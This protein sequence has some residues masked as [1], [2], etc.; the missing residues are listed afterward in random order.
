MIHARAAI[1]LRHGNTCKSQLSGFL[2]IVTRETAG[3]VNF[4]GVWLYFGLREF[5]YAFLQKLL[6][7]R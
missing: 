2:E 3:L 7:F 6:F 4:L 1:I 5:A